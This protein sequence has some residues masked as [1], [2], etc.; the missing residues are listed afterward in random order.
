MP[1]L[2]C[3]CSYMCLGD[4]W[5]ASPFSCARRYWGQSV[6]YI[7]LY[8]ELNSSPFMSRIGQI[9]DPT[10]GAYRSQRLP[11][12][13]SKSSV[14]P[15]DG[16]A[17]AQAAR[18]PHKLKPAAISYEKPGPSRDLSGNIHSYSSGQ[19]LP[20]SWIPHRAKPLHVVGN[21]SKTLQP[22]RC[23]VLP[24]EV[25]GCILDHLRAFHEA[26]TSQGCQT[27]HLRDLYSLALTSR[28][29]DKAVV[30][31]LSV[32]PGLRLITRFRQ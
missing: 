7:D 13:L 32:L 8:V 6:S 26:P 14:A 19:S 23:N 24:P 11:I 25:Y 3:P 17:T 29:W 5:A 4:E 16:S 31:E 9:W 22:H 30:K 18:A 28:W 1:G 2:L 20:E 15:S 10:L 27:C 21:L 12:A